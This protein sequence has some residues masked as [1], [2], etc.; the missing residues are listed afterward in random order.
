MRIARPR[1]EFA[2]VVKGLWTAGEDDA[3]VR[4]K[5][6]GLFSIPTDPRAQPP[7]RT[8]VRDRW[9]AAVASGH[10]VLARRGV[11][12]GKDSAADMG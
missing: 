2:E 7:A 3:F 4:D 12:G 10:P 1:T 6:A 5:Q 9:T 11:R 8:S